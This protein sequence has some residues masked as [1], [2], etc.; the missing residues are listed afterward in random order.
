MSAQPYTPG[1]YAVPPPSFQSPNGTHHHM[2]LPPPHLAHG[3]SPSE[4]VSPAQPHF[5]LNGIPPSPYGPMSPS[6]YAHPG[7]VPV[8]MSIPSLPPLQH[9][10]P[11]P[12]PGPQSPSNAYAPPPPTGPPFIVQDT[13]NQYSSPQPTNPTPPYHAMNG[14]TKQPSPQADVYGPSPTHPVHRDGMPQNRRGTARRGSFGGSR[15]PPCLFFP[16]G[17]C[18]NGYV[19]FQ[20]IPYGSPHLKYLYL[21]FQR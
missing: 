6:A 18:K 8:P 20:S 1:Y 14:D 5:V 16:A 9:Q 11:L 21:C 7:Q 10:P 13:S 15:K 3:R 19:F 17:R 4:G 2:S 12:P